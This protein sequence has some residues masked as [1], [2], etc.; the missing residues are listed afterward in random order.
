MYGVVAS[1]FVSP[2]PLAVAQILLHVRLARQ[3]PP[4]RGGRGN[5]A[6]HRRGGGRE[7]RNRT[8]FPPFPSSFPKLWQ[9]ERTTTWEEER[10]L[11]VSQ[12]PPLPPMCV[13]KRDGRME[14]SLSLSE[15]RGGSGVITVVASPL[16]PPPMQW[17]PPRA[18]GFG[19]F[20][21]SFFPPLP[22]S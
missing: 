22:L 7:S 14:T 4:A 6:T 16:K 15:G 3:F 1:C 17:L 12:V 9:H 21:S 18:L 13:C 10:C 5:L 11:L 20:S 19:Y 2:P 8:Q